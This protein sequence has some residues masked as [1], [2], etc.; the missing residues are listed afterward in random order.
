MI[1]NPDA[2]VEQLS[3]RLNWRLQYVERRLAYLAHLS[4]VRQSTECPGKFYTVSPR[5]GMEP[6]LARREATLQQHQK[7]LAES[8]AMFAQLT[9]D[10][11][12]M[13]ELSDGTHVERLAGFETTRLRMEE[14][15]YDCE[16]EIMTTVT[17]RA[18]T[19]DVLEQSKPIDE[20]LLRRGL[21]LR[22]IYLDSAL[23]CAAISDYANWFA[24]AGAE[25]R[26]IPILPVGLAIYDRR[27]ALVPVDPEGDSSGV[28][29]L[30]GAGVVAAL[31]SLYEFTWQHAVA[32]SDRDRRNDDGLNPQ[33]DYVLDLMAK[34]LTD[35]VI[36][37]RLGV[38][39]RTVRRVTA[40]LMDVLGAQ[41]RF[42]A[43][44]LAAVSGWL[45][46]V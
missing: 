4:L 46:N 43:G 23:N 13:Q 40:H 35:E 11:H 27:I 38:S 17:G 9:A 18:Q 34:G 37:R 6:L 5:V 20:L 24:A 7:E 32:L 22:T 16:R 26:S 39:V 29:L 25:V 42:Q 30:R 45:K 8:R 36:A 28:V 33:E 12:S 41:S 19:R 15:A 3:R 21:R 1:N 31:C 14:L 2:D 44:A 10:Y